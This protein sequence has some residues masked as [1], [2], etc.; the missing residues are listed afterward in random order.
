MTA[1]EK[2]KLF[3][4]CVALPAPGRHFPPPQK[5]MGGGKCR[6]YMPSERETLKISARISLQRD[7]IIRA[8][9]VWP[10]GSV[11]H[12]GYSGTFLTG[13]Q[14]SGVAIFEGAESQDM[15]RWGAE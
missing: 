12:Y 9:S 5:K 8:V 11:K 7:L 2:N 15:R 4:E 6:T 3:A 1:V 14:V 10:T 13:R